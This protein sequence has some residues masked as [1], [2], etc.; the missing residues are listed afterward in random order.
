MIKKEISIIQKKG[1]NYRLNSGRI[2]KQ[3]PWLGDLLSFKY[4]SIMEKSIFPKK[5]L[6]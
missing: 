5:I 6:R 4:D 1:I 2:I 3:K